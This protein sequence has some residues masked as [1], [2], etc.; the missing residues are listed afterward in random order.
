MV[1]VLLSIIGES[2]GDEEECNLAPGFITMV[3]LWRKK[4]VM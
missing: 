1:R 3:G 4:L 2:G